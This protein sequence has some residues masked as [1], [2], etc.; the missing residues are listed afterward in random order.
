MEFNLMPKM[1]V[2]FER[3]NPIKWNHKSQR[4]RSDNNIIVLITSGK[5]IIIACNVKCK[6]INILGLLP[7]MHLPPI[8]KIRFLTFRIVFSLYSFLS[9][10]WVN[11]TYGHLL[12]YSIRSLLGHV[13]YHVQRYKL[14]SKKISFQQRNEFF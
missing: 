12:S 3:F 8:V 5:L 13:T 14:H 4:I 9:V 1:C 2:S 11:K 7:S 6:E 10:K